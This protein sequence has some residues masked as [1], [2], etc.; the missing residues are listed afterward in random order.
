MTRFIGI[1]FGTVFLAVTAQAADFKIDPD[2]STVGF[3]IKHLAIST[4]P[5]RFTGFGG[6][7]SFDPSNVEA[8]KAEVKIGVKSINTEQAKR[9]N[10]LRSP[11]FFDIEKYPEMNFKTTKIEA[12]SKDTFTAVGDLTIHGVTKP[13]SLAVKF[14]GSAKDP[15]GHDRV[16]FSAT[17]RINRKD[18]GLTWNRALETGGLLVGEDVD[19]AIEIEA[20]KQG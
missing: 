14:G 11:D 17:T 9:D 18:F 15:M 12:D 4:V 5:G 7:F 13:V 20:I 19:I 1:I 8:S 10:H 3:R 2:H 16:A 6:S